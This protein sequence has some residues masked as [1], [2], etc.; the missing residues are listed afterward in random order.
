MQFNP[1]SHQLLTCALSDI[2]LWSVEQK[3]VQK[4]K[5]GGRVNC[6][7]WT[8]DGQYMALGLA[9]GFV[10]IRNKVREM[11]FFVNENQLGKH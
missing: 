3:A 11:F 7:S 10:S 1:V 8:K 5:S 6:C 9:T 2:A 4:Y